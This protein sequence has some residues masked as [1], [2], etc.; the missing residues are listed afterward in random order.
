[1]S[2]VPVTRSPVQNR[3]LMA[4]CIVIITA[5]GLKGLLSR[6]YVPSDGWAIALSIIAS[7]RLFRESR[8]PKFRRSTE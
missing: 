4:A 7:V 6:H 2:D 1:M 3:V 5:T 8:K